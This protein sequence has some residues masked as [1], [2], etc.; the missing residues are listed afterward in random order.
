MA[1]QVIAES[2]KAP[3]RFGEIVPDF[4]WPFGEQLID[5]PQSRV[6]GLGWFRA[7]A[8]HS[9][10]LRKL[11]VSALVVWMLVFGSPWIASST[12]AISPLA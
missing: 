1:D 6:S 12:L 10:P 11:Q 9:R 7:V 5:N 8:D 4:N 2:G 3:C